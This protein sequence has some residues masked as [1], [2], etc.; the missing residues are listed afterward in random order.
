MTNHLS[1][2]SAAGIVALAGC[3]QPSEQAPSPLVDDEWTVDSSASNLSY[4][5]VKSGEV[6][7]VN[8]FTQLSGNVTP[9]GTATVEIDLSSV[10]TGVDI[11]DERM[12]EV[13]FNVAQN[14]K[15]TV[16][17]QIDPAAFESLAVGESTVQ[18]LSA[19]LSLAGIERDIDT[20]LRVTRAGADRVIATTTDPVIVYADAFG[21]GTG[22]D[23]L[24]ELAGL[25][26]ITPA[27]PVTFSI[28]FER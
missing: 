21:L 19:T 20:E 24:R 25:D 10:S 15:A 28:A 13:F 1:L 6:L 23:Q 4:V 12:R 16:T 27:V 26:T 22:I 2:L 18:P 17:A 9:E 14:P 7:E 11:R 3:A 5:S 8:E